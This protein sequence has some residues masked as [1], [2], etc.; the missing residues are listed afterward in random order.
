MTSQPILTNIILF[1]LLVFILWGIIQILLKI[2]RSNEI[3]YKKKAT[4]ITPA[5]RS[6]MKVLESIV[7]KNHRVFV[8][9]RI[10][11]VITPNTQNKKNWWRLFA[12]ISSKHFDYVI[13]HKDTFEVVAVVELNDK[14]HNLPK[15]IERD[16]YIKVA[17][18]TA[19][20]VLVNI[21]ARKYYKTEE[22][23]TQI[24]GEIE[25]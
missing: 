17:C 20:L 1:L 18:L 5:E 9:V 10:A 15:R 14:S 21:K 4:L 24:Y 23:K 8:Q 25:E 6:F 16:K 19:N 7:Q 11:D 12:Q 2:K 22:V 3:Q 13:C